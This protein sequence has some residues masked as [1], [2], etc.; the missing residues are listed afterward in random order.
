MPGLT[1]HVLY[2]TG[3]D[4]ATASR[5]YSPFI[6]VGVVM[7]SVYGLTD[8]ASYQI[9]HKTFSNLVRPSP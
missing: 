9:V 1:V 2:E 8:Q 4:H 7:L 6:V 3:H 5:I